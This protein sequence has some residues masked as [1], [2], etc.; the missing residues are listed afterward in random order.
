M[1]SSAGIATH[2]GA[3]VRR[4]GH[5]DGMHDIRYA[6]RTLAKNRGFTLTAGLTLA[7]GIGGAVAT[8]SIVNAVLLRPLPIAQPDRL[9]LIEA[10][11]ATDHNT[12]GASWT[13]FQTLRDV[14][15][16]FGGVSAYFMARFPGAPT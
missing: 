1:G 10:Q 14:T 7:I 15:H 12:V 11:G 9:A 4:L 6:L 2:F 16:A 5:N 3:Q 8:F 13:K